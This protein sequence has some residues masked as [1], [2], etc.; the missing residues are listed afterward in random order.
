MPGAESAV[1]RGAGGA[2]RPGG[3]RGVLP[4]P[5]PRPLLQARHTPA[6]RAGGAGGLYP[7]PGP[8]LPA[9]HTV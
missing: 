1:Q 3:E 8:A 7:R 4:L 5:G 2:V 9:C 6:V